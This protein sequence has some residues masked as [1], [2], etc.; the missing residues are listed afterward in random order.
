MLCYFLFLI[1]YVEYTIYTQKLQII[2][3]KIVGIQ[4]WGRTYF[5]LA[6]RLEVKS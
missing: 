5:Q 4:Q 6:I 1:I 3:S 2:L